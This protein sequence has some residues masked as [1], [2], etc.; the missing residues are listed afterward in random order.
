MLRGGIW[1]GIDQETRNGLRVKT[2][3]VCVCRGHESREESVRYRTDIAGCSK[4][5]LHD[6]VAAGIRIEME[7]QHVANY[8][9]GGVGDHL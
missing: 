2:Y 6:A 5:S 3:T 7:L 8:G 9:G 4:V 1:S